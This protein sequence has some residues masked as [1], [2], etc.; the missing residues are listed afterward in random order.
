LNFEVEKGLDFYS[1][2]NS[3]R[4]HVLGQF[5]EKPALLSWNNTNEEESA[6][7]TYGH[8]Q[9]LH[10]DATYREAEALLLKMS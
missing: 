9:K 10:E 1:N 6:H 2:C 8:I 3:H 5:T 4:H 7:D